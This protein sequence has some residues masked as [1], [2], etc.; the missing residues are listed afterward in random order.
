MILA[1]DPI[2]QFQHRRS[3]PDR[4][5][6]PLRD[7]LH[8]FGGLHAAGGGRAHLCSWSAPPPRKAWCPSR[9]QSA[10]E[11][12]YEFVATT[13]RTHRRHRRHE[14]LPLRVH[15]VHVRAD[16]EHDR[17]DPVRLHRH[18]PHHRHRGAGDYGVPDRADLR[19]LSPRLALLQ[20]VRAQGRA[21]LHPAADRL[22]RGP[23]VHVAADLAQ[24]APV[25]QH[26]GRPHHAQGVR[27]LHHPARQRARRARLGRRH[28]AVRA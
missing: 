14:V 26:A 27:R 15:D 11:L 12:S 4:H 21:D 13:V 24:R 9:L 23:V 2:H 17:A 28:P 5:G 22:H 7:R 19:P 8:Q 10:A 16:A 6:R 25:R 18:Q 20:S 3:V 1:V